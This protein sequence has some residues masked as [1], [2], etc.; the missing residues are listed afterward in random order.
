LK[1][2][3]VEWHYTNFE[4]AVTEGGLEAA[5]RNAIST[6]SFINSTIYSSKSVAAAII[7]MHNGMLL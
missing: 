6:F 5:S 7:T 1:R 3:E 4:L 2:K